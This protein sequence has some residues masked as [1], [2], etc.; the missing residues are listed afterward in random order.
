MKNN[1]P[2]VSII[3]PVYNTGKLLGHTIDCIIAQSYKNWELLLIDDG[4]TDHICSEI[5][6]KYALA[7]DRI[8]SFHKK[9]GGICSARNYGLKRAQGEFIAFCDHDDEYNKYLIEKALKSS[10]ED[11]VD[12]TKFC[13][14]TVYENGLV[15]KQTI[16]K[17]VENYDNIPQ[18]FLKLINI[19]VFGTIWSCLYKRQVIIDHSLKFDETISHGGEDFNF[20][21]RLLPFVTKIDIIPDYLY[22]HYIRGALS[23]SVKV[24]NDTLNIYIKEISLINELI[25]RFNSK[26]RSLR[27]EEYDEAFTFRMLEYISY[28][29]RLKKKKSDIIDELRNLE[30][31]YKGEYF[32]GS[33]R[34][35]KFKLWVIIALWR[36]HLFSFLYYLFFLKNR[37]NSLK[38]KKY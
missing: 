36:H 33:D 10:I 12:I 18:S 17:K 9:N 2:L 34:Q 16:C 32:Y 29:I 27:K 11:N 22:K 1:Y 14:D 13:Y 4:S 28:A 24:Y 38:N 3:M 25:V 6:D 8:L 21:L 7:D 35:L 23:T 15:E 26:K 30:N 37:L 5:C 31:K 19:N 20:N